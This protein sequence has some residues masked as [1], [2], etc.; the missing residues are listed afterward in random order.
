MQKN[1]RNYTIRLMNRNFIYA[2][3]IGIIVLG[4]FAYFI[5]GLNE[6][7]ASTNI[8]SDAPPATTKETNA[9]VKIEDIKVGTGA[10]VK[11]GDTIV[12]D[13]T[14]TLAN[15]TKFDSSL[16]RGTPFETQIGVG[17]VIKGWD[18]GVIGMKVGGERK[19]TIPPELGYGD[20]GQGSIP[21]NSVLIFDVILRE[22]K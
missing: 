17:Q 10:A 21:P 1:K 4:V 14:G 13:Y 11:S 9:N 7:P 3:V 12:I 16:D 18:L 19:L 8:T 20:Q 2:I 5:F 6:G 22:I 15:G